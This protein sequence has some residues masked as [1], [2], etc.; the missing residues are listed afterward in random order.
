MSG[1][2][3]SNALVTS[4][5]ATMMTAMFTELRE[6]MINNNLTISNNIND[7]RAEMSSNGDATRA[8]LLERIDQR[9]RLSTRATTR[10]GSR[11]VSPKS[12]MAG[13]NAKLKSD[14]DTPDVPEVHNGERSASAPGKTE[15]CGTSI[16]R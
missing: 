2:D 6:S 14:A 3:D 5:T 7:L 4:A 13:V 9:S 16:C 11:A 8:E 1:E 15:S 10:A 12:L